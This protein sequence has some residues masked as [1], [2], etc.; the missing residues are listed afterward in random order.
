MPWS[1]ASIKSE[2]SGVLKEA[3][4][5]EASSD[6]SILTYVPKQFDFGTPA[7]ALDYL[8]EKAKN[9]GTGF[10]LSDV[11]R[12]TTGVDEIEKLSEEQKIENEVLNRIAVI[13]EEAYTKA[14][15]LGLDEGLQKALADKTGEINHQ[16]SELDTMM[17]H[18]SILKEELVRQNESHI[19]Q[20]VYSIASRIAFDHIEEKP[21]VV[22]SVVKNA[23]EM[24]QAEED[25]NVL[26]S[27]VQIDFLENIKAQAGREFEFLKKV[28]F[29][30]S[31]QVSSGGCIIE[32][33]YGI[34]DARIEER[35][36]K[37]WSELK[38]A[39]P[40]VKSP[41]S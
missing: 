7:A 4:G 37:L 8:R 18:I 3:T 5:S 29:Q 35:V 14:Y 33:N 40:R 24:A 13:Q 6:V 11:L 10:I 30:P 31:A 26:V 17:S 9:N 36:Q 19:V 12:R 25:V 34:V 2:S 38:Q 21:E 27:S 28:K 22:I 39:L 15:Q 1:R 23:I 41:I 32:T 16:M 20:L